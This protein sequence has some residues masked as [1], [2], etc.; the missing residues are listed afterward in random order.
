MTY[1]SLI[2]LDKSGCHL[3]V[4][5]RI[6]IRVVEYEAGMFTMFYPPDLIQGFS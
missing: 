5:M 6:I 4:I 3:S 1:V 2:I